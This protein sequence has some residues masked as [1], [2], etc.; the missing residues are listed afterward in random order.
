MKICVDLIDHAPCPVVLYLAPED[1]PSIIFCPRNGPPV[2]VWSQ[3]CQS[4]IVSFTFS[5]VTV[6][7]RVAPRRPGFE[8]RGWAELFGSALWIL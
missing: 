8:S 3:Q 1:P 5:Y 6:I 4:I 2:S 7:E